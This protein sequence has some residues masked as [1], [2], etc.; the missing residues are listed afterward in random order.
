MV[1]KIFV[2]MRIVRDVPTGI[3]DRPWRNDDN[4]RRADWRRRHD[5]RRRRDHDRRSGLS[6][7]HD[8]GQR[9]SDSHMHANAGMRRGHSSDQDRGK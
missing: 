6:D 3:H 7:D 2:S 1:V 9:N 4:G 8:T 5:D